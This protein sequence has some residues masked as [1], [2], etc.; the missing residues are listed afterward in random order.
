MD[1][2]LLSPRRRLTF[3]SFEDGTAV[4]GARSARAPGSLREGTTNVVADT[5]PT[6]YP[7]R[8]DSRT[9]TLPGRSSPLEAGGLHRIFHPVHPSQAN[10]PSDHRLSGLY[11]LPGPSA[12]PPCDWM[13][14][15]RD[16]V[17]RGSATGAKPGL[18]ISRV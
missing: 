15:R 3:T 6:A 4:S 13:S 14:A 16:Y 10:H 12:R 18:P 1:D 17:E 5:G 9:D 11:P 8:I 7:R 2:E